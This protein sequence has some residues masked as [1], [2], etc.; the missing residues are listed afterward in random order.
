MNRPRRED[1]CYQCYRRHL[2]EE[3]IELEK[4]LKPRIVWTSTIIVPDAKKKDLPE[5]LR[6]L[7]R[8]RVRGTFDRSLGHRMPNSLS[9]K[10]RRERLLKKLRKQGVIPNE[11]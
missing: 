6:P 2:K 11:T 8:M 3:A 1:E 7:V 4:R 5:Y 10:H 9:E